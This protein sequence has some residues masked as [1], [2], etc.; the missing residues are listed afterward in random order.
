MTN[1]SGKVQE[2]GDVSQFLQVKLRFLSG[3]RS[4]RLSGEG[5]HG[6]AGMARVGRVGQ[7]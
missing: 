1:I 3:Q 6:R 4:D 2:F 5:R 7:Q